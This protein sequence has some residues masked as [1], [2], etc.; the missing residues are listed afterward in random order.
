MS[1]GVSMDQNEKT[2]E[3]NYGSNFPKTSHMQLTKASFRIKKL[4][5]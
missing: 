4:V 1:T 2:Q 5:I 3:L